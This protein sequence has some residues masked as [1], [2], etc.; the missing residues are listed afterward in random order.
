M[1]VVCKVITHFRVHIANR[2]DIQTK[3]LLAKNFAISK[4]FYFFPK[5][6]KPPKKVPGNEMPTSCV[7]DVAE[8]IVSRFPSP[9]VFH[10]VAL[11]T[12]SLL[13]SP[14][15][16]LSSWLCEASR[17]VATGG[18]A[19]SLHTSSA[20][21]T[22]SQKQMFRAIALFIYNVTIGGCV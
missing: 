12:S 16:W 3:N 14:V 13:P 18:G 19:P 17:N 11:P 6:S 8:C 10:N 2:P 4:D 15:G 5:P 21:F 9:N 1:A 7:M 22:M 20:L